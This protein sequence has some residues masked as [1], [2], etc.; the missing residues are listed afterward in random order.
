MTATGTLEQLVQE[1]LTLREEL[2]A[3]RA[4]RTRVVLRPIGARPF[5]GQAL[6]VEAAVSEIVSGRP[7][8]DVPVTFVASW[9][10]LTGSDGYSTKKGTTITLRTDAD[11]RATVDLSPPVSEDLL[12]S[13]QNSLQ[14]Q[15][16]S[17]DPEAATP[18]DTQQALER[19]AVEYRWEA[20]LEF[21]QAVDIYFR[22]FGRRIR[23]ALDTRD[24]LANWNHLDAA[25]H[26]Y[27]R[28]DEP[29]ELDTVVQGAAVLDVHF[30]DWLGAWL[31]VMRDVAA[32]ENPLPN[33]F[34]TLKKV[35]RSANALLEGVYAHAHSYV[36]EQFGKAGEFIG[37]K[38][39]E[40]SIR[41]FVDA[42]IADLDT[43]TKVALGPGL[44]IASS[45]I[46]TGNL[47]VLTA[48]GQARTDLRKEIETGSSK[49]SADILRVESDVATKVA[50]TDFQQ[51]A[52]TVSTSLA[53]KLNSITFNT[54]QNQLNTQLASKVDRT[55]LDEAIAGKADRTFVD[56]A[57]TGKADRTELDQKLA[58]KL[59]SV[60]LGPAL[61]AKADRAFV[62]S[63]LTG[64][65]DRTELDQKLS[66]KADQSTLT[67]ALAGKVDRAEMDQKLSSKLDTAAF[68]TFQSGLDQRFAT[69]VE[70]T[71]FS[72]AMA[73]KVDT[74]QFTAF[75]RG[76]DDKL[77]AQQVRI[78]D[79]STR[80]LDANRFDQFSTTIT[81]QVNR[82]DDTATRL[83]TR[84]TGVE[85]RLPPIIIR[86][87]NR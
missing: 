9:G 12:E 43:D 63:A 46:G 66:G 67:A 1:L 70:T 6:S 30:R 54:F 3:M 60:A 77:R 68:S 71:T 10:T 76:T 86:P 16:L 87:P 48:L 42:G 24:Y 20:N 53:T 27:A 44:N 85:G 8:I 28:E 41:A 18:R 80:K 74:A 50:A 49:L 51:F 35:D 22:D 17:L 38:V 73:T 34:E 26:A 59:D 21:R 45:A 84:V 29:G 81:A 31:A 64:K 61:A 78:D 57:L 19:I 33:R 32:R 2:S 47:Q 79:L 58:A 62:D 39:A 5:L 36:R 14:A 40:Q 13:Q 52:T 56:A 82:I 65:A 72:S 75:Q 55:T 69:K 25:I 83:N 37:Q 15:L 7:R 11:G 4:A 23:E